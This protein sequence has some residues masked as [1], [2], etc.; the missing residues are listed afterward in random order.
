MASCVNIQYLF[1][2]NFKVIDEFRGV[3]CVFSNISNNK[4]NDKPN[5]KI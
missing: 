4:F 3:A 1:A 2:D 5:N